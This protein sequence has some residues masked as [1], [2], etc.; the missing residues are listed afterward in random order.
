MLTAADIDKRIRMSKADCVIADLQTAIKV[1]QGIGAGLKTKI[2]VE[3]RK[4][5]NEM[6]DQVEKMKLKGI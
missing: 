6:Q 5:S 1:D 2:L 3:E 4:A